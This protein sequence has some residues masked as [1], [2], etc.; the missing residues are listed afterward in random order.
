VGVQAR[1]F[2]HARMHDL[3]WETTVPLREGIAE[4]YAWIAAEVERLGL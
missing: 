1:N 2:S 3:G 4:T